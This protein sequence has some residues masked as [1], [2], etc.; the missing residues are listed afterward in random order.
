MGG[1]ASLPARAALAPIALASMLVLA[2]GC[3]SKTAP[4]EPEPRPAE[5]ETL[6]RELELAERR[7][8]QELER[9]LAQ[10]PGA[11]GNTE[12][13][14]VNTGA[15]NDQA[16][17]PADGAKPSQARRDEKM[18][19]ESQD[20]AGALPEK[21]QPRPACDLVCRALASMKRS[22]ERICA[23]AG[24]AEARCTRARQRVSTAVQRVRGSGCVCQARSE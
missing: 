8:G 19:A 6:E 7:L 10:I 11:G 14:Q 21:S 12:S 9:N 15:D 23:L 4:R 24:E 16:R 1:G 18:R 2:G 3:M 20:Q 13:E 17:P 5:L 22:T